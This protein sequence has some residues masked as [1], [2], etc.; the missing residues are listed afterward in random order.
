MPKLVSSLAQVDSGTEVKQRFLA[1]EPAGAAARPTFTLHWRHGRAGVVNRVSPPVD[2]QSA[3]RL[4]LQPAEAPQPPQ[5]NTPA[6]TV[7]PLS[8][9][10]TTITTRRA[11]APGLAGGGV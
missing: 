4:A 9:S 6:C 7:R 3:P 8:P 1:S 10:A 2:K 5:A 11:P